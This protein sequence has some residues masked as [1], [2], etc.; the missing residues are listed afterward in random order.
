MIT[1]KECLKILFKAASLYKNNF[2]GNKY[3][4]LF[5]DEHRKPEYIEIVFYKASFLHMTGLLFT[6]EGAN[7][8]QF[9]DLC[10]KKRLRETDFEFDS[11]GF[12]E[13]KLGVI[14]YLF[15]EDMS[16]RTIGD[17]NYSQPVLQTDKLVGG[18]YACLGVLKS[19]KGYYFPNTT[20][21]GNIAELVTR[22]RPIVAIFKKPYSQTLYGTMVYK[23]K[24]KKY[25]NFVI[26]NRIKQFLSEEVIASF[27]GRGL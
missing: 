7:P 2:L 26:P 25:E 21:S 3:L 11:T 1:K 16:A 12:A 8:S 19:S 13:L 24:D 14:E 27:S 17:Y 10:L 15:A 6:R 18:T 23:T 4:V 20:R 9:F 22:K 5:I